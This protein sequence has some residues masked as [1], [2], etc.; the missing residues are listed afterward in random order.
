M[1]ESFPNLISFQSRIVALVESNTQ[2]Y[3]PSKAAANVLSHDLEILSVGNSFPN[4]N[5]KKVLDV[6]RHIFALFPK[7]KEIRTH[8]GQNEDQWDYI[9]SLVQVFQ[10]VCLDSTTHLSLACVK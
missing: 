6:A 5:P 10:G 9:H 1:A 7:L 4:L 3:E 8:K 2:V